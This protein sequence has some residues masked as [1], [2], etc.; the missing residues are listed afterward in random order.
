MRPSL[1][2]ILLFLGSLLA[3]LAP[4]SSSALLDGRFAHDAGRWDRSALPAEDLASLE[5]WNDSFSETDPPRQSKLFPTPP[6]VGPHQGSE[7]PARVAPPA[8][9]AALGRPTA[10]SS[11]DVP[12]APPSCSLL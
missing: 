7:P 1:L 5:Q 4:A 11:P 2:V 9:R 8:F 3:G 12:R 6:A 10:P